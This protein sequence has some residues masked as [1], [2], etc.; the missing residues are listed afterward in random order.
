MKVSL[1][2]ACDLIRIENHKLFI[3][4]TAEEATEL[5]RELDAKIQRMRNHQKL[6]DIDAADARRKQE[7]NERCR[8]CGHNPC[9]TWCGCKQ[10]A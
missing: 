8:A 2:A 9:A 7:R 4:L 3:Y 6:I 5:R 10:Y 1:E